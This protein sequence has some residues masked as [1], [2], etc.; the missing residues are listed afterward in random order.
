LA[1]LSSLF[2]I[3]TVF[4]SVLTLLIPHLGSSVVLAATLTRMFVL[5]DP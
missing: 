2:L 5:G 1:I 4:L 3:Q